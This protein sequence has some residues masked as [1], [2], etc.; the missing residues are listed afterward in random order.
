M[1]LLWRRILYLLAALLM[2]WAVLSAW[3]LYSFDT[4]NFKRAAS[5]WMQTHRARE[6]ALDGPVRLQRWPQPA[7]A[8]RRVRLS[9]RGRPQQLFASIE[10]AALSLPNAAIGTVRGVTRGATGVARGAADVLRSVPG[11]S[12]PGQR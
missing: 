2:L 7:V 4:G 3:L 8:V 10:Q 9:E 1:R 6:R 5:A 12:M 11:A